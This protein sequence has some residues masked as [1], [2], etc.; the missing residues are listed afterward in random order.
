MELYW[1]QDFLALVR[2]RNFS[3]AAT[4]RHVTQSAFSRRIQ[5]LED[6]VGTPLFDRSAHPVEL[7]PAGQQLL[8]IAVTSVEPLLDFRASIRAC[9]AGA[10]PTVSF[11]M[12]TPCSAGIFPMLIARLLVD[13]RDAMGA[14][15][16]N[17][18]C[19]RLAPELAR[20]SGG[21]SRLRILTNL[22][23]RRTVTVRGAVPTAILDGGDHGR[24]A[25]LASGIVEASVFA[26]RDPSR[27]ATHNKG[28]MNGVD[29]VLLALGQDWRAVEAGAHSWAARTGCYRPLATWRVNGDQLEGTMT[30]PIAVGVVGGV[31]RVHPAVQ[32]GFRVA[33]VASAG[34]LA[35]VTAAVGLAQNLG[36]LRALASDGIQGGHMR[37]HARKSSAAPAVEPGSRNS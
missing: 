14:N 3:R 25:D 33:G 4:E 5:A 7:T 22:C 37:L 9:A 34:E 15:T 36:A 6:W 30:L 18:M 28:I 31:V 24:S 29:A 8:P 21:R 1:L 17:S 2:T 19:E 11:V 20:L 12:P 16:V 32:A 13:V 26:E 35:A 23:D 27:A 10:S